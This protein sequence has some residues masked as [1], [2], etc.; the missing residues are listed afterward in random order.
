MLGYA[1]ANPTYPKC[2]FNSGKTVGEFNV[3]LR[4]ANPTYE[5]FI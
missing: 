5:M 4:C 3:G 1:V 2:L